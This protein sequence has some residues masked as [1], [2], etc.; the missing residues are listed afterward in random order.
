MSTS[1]LDKI[2]QL[3]Q[4]GIAL[5]S[6]SDTPTLLQQIL[7]SAQSLT[8]ADGGTLYRVTNQQRLHFDVVQNTSLDIKLG[9]NHPDDIT[10]P[11]TPL[12]LPDGTENLTTVSSY[13]ALKG[14]TVNIADIYSDQEFDFSGALAFDQQ[15]HYRTQSMLTIPL[16]NFDSEVIGVLQLINATDLEGKVI[17]FSEESESLA[18]SLASQ[19]SIALTN[20]QLIEEHKQ[21][22]EAFSKMVADAID[23][24]SPY[25]GEHC[26]R[27]PVITMMLA[28]AASQSQHPDFKNFRMDENDF[29]ELETAAWLHDCGKLTTPEYIMDKSTKLETVFDRI[30]LIRTRLNV[31]AFQS[32]AEQ[33][34]ISREDIKASQKKYYDQYQRLQA[35]NI[36]KEFFN[37]ASADFLETIQS[38]TYQA[39]D[40]S[41]QSLLSDDEF[42]NLNIARGTLNEQERNIMQDH[43]A[44][45]IRM[46]D[47]LP[48][49][50]ELQRVSEY[51]G[52]HHERM[53]G[54]GYPNQL[55][56]EALSI[57]ARIMG[58][59]DI[60]EA[61]S[62]GD[63]PYKKAKTLSE[64]LRILGFMKQ[65]GHIDPDLFNLFIREK[66]YL[67]YAKTYLK[68]SQIDEVDHCL[69][70][71]YE[72]T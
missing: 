9:G 30:E 7:T 60:F 16:K 32:L 50:K 58:I 65:E 27:V 39:L 72:A 37:E 40:G 23:K 12:T 22:F 45:S 18:R 62:A 8:Q 2:E 21:L 38:D 44:M 47:I 1:L 5:S 6:E 61:L 53:D 4:V 54:K 56:R 69:I 28:E 13:V 68:P 46:L 29:F 55:T 63:R 3:N 20:R 31:K 41:E 15:F 52:G 10:F 49:P 33:Y 51:A 71:G 59:A 11:A 35:I 34:N 66:V 64:S 57:P 42:L 70:P 17:P 19:A 25:T 67:T 43:A 26:Q 48:F 24:K 36:G 14:E